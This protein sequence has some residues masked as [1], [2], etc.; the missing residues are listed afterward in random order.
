[1]LDSGNDHSN[2]YVL[3]LAA[4][5]V[6]YHFLHCSLARATDQTISAESLILLTM[7]LFPNSR[8]GNEK[9]LG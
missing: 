5:Q 4:H 9:L 7:H 6:R 1:M 2:G 3:L 8:F